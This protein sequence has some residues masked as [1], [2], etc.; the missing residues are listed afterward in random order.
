MTENETGLKK[1]ELIN[2][3]NKKLENLKELEE[4]GKN[5]NYFQELSNIAL[6]QLQLEQFVES[7]ENYLICLSH[8]KK[9]KDRLGQAAVYGVLGTLYFKKSAYEKSIEFYENA[10]EIYEELRQ[11]KEKITCL[12]GIGNNYI[13]LNLFDEACD[14]FLDCSAICS[15]NNDIYNLLDCLERLIYVHEINKK[16]D[17]VFELYK[18]SLKAFKGIKD[19]KGVITSYFNLGIL[20]KKN[21]DLEEALRYF[22]K[23]TN[24][25]IDVNYVELIIRGLGYVGE[26]L[27]YIGKIKE[28]KNQFIRAL[29]IAQDIN[30]KNAITQIRILLQSLGLQDKNIIKELKEYEKK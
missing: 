19:K 23:G 18:K 14:I 4:Y 30:A 10:Y 29:R 13:K 7:E 25:A 17:V 22:K 16:W 9:H 11:V 15:D 3:L 20:Q 5:S 21:N 28:A 6:I 12:K 24:V 2:L 1:G 26:T 8:F 27:F